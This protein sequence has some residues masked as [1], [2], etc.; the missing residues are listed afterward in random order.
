MDIDGEL[1]AAQEQ[2]ALYR[3]VCLYL[4]VHLPEQSLGQA[5]ESL[6]DIYNW[7]REQ[8]RLIPETRRQGTLEI[9]GMTQR[10][11]TPFIVDEGA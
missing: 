4:I 3:A 5:Y 9:K 6:Y 8:S 11:R 10:E 7:T 1:T 2:A